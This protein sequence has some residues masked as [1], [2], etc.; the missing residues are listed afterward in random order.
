MTTP[1]ADPASVQPSE[2]LADAFECA[3]AALMRPTTIPAI[4]HC[5]DVLRS[6][7]DAILARF[8]TR[9]AAVVDYPHIKE[10]YTLE[11]IEAKIASHDYG[12]EHLLQH[13]MLLLRARPVA[14][15]VHPNLG[16]TF[17]P[18]MSIYA[19]PGTVVR[20]RAGGGYPYEKEHAMKAGFV[21]NALY[22]VKRCDIG[23][24]KTQVLF[25][26]IPGRWNSCLFAD[27]A[28]EPKSAAPAEPAGWIKPE[29]GLPP[30]DVDV[31]VWSK[32]PWEKEPSAKIDQW[33]MQRE[34]P[35]PFSLATI[36]TGF[37]WN[38]HDDFYYVLAWQP[39]TA[40][41]ATPSPAPQAQQAPSEPSQSSS[42]GE[43][44]QAYLEAQDA[45]DNRELQGPN[46]DDYF[47]LLRRRNDARRDLDA[48]LSRQA[49]AAPAEARK[50][51]HC[52]KVF[53]DVSD[54]A[55]HERATLDHRVMWPG[56]APTPAEPAK[57]EAARLR[58][59]SGK[60]PTQEQ[61]DEL[62]RGVR[63]RAA[64]PPTPEAEPAK[65]ID[66][67]HD[68]EQG[69]MLNPAWLKLHGLTAKQAVEAEPVQQDT[70]DEPS[71]DTLE[72]AISN[73]ERL[74]LEDLNPTRVRNALFTLKI[75]LQVNRIATPPAEKQAAP[76][77]DGLQRLREAYRPNVLDQEWTEHHS[78]NYPRKAAAII[79][80]ARALLLATPAAPSG[81]GEAS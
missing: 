34:A 7:V 72:A 73:T 2:E 1:H 11:E 36:E 67:P 29:D 76:S 20:F 41:G 21:M 66:D 9:P 18:T 44:I 68:I 51:S 69:R 8:G 46:A 49:P 75:R 64:T 58:S 81:E 31:L 39:I 79:N 54:A 80:A 24:S 30:P 78:R 23:H 48:A 65:W 25:D 3:R 74:I 57:T 52:E 27:I 40:P 13:A 62:W 17:E 14:E 10:P 56:A 19:Q 77:G 63:E 70:E 26:E 6:R 47:I 33:A 16:D 22:T 55:E 38:E 50:C 28:A 15:P 32:Q 12:A 71:N 42:A 59:L 53:T 43:A 35:L 5:L 61:I 37:G 60:A 4:G 45:L